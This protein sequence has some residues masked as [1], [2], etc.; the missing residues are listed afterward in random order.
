M[1]KKIALVTHVLDYVGPPAVK[2]FLENGYDV[3][4][5]DP[6]FKDANRQEDYTARNPGSIPLGIE[7]P[8]NLVR[9]V[10]DHH[11]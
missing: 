1:R 11:R 5:H 10:W 2:A 9:H 6:A 4:A 7:E 8:E 3:V